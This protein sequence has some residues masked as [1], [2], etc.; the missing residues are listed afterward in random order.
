MEHGSPSRPQLMPRTPPPLKLQPVDLDTWD[1]GTYADSFYTEA[2]PDEL[3]EPWPYRF[4][5]GDLVWVKSTGGR[6]YHGKVVG[7]AKLGRTIQ[8][9]GL[10][11]WL[12]VFSSKFRK[13]F[14]PLNGEIKPD[15]QH[16]RKLL[17]EAGWPE[18]E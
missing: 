16:T 3:D 13:Y 6:W 18:S 8:G 12:V 7:Q 10:L 2:K 14:A 11:F 15:T 4:K 1:D 9:E 17:K 5:S